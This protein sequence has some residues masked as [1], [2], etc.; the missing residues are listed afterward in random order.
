MR[1]LAVSLATISVLATPTFTWEVSVCGDA[2]Y[3]LP[4]NRGWICASADPI[5]PGTACPLKGDKASTH[6]IE[7]LVSYNDGTCVAPEDAKCVF[8]TDTTWGCVFPSFGCRGNTPTTAAPTTQCETWDYDEDDLTSSINADILDGIEDYDESWSV[9]VT[10]VTKLFACGADKS[11]AA[12]TPAPTPASTLD[13]VDSLVYKPTPT[14]TSFAKDSPLLVTATQ[15]EDASAPALTPG[16][17]DESSRVDT[18]VGLA[19]GKIPSPAP[20]LHASSEASA[21]DFGSESTSGTTNLSATDPTQADLAPEPTI[22]HELLE[23]SQST[24]CRRKHQNWV[25]RR[26]QR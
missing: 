5:P 1:R 9:E 11:T 10:K 22:T 15:S 14:S 18:K 25:K 7:N 24:Q 4:E 20:T 26:R 17:T 23:T 8:V 6:C 13:T 3:D 12:P 19:V 21:S 2:T 16:I